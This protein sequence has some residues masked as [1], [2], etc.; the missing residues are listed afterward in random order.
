MKRLNGRGPLRLQ[1]EP[2]T[3]AIGERRQR[4]LVAARQRGKI[5]Q[6]QDFVPGPVIRDVADRELDLRQAIR[7][8]TDGRSARAAPEAATKCAEAAQGSCACR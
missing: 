6:H 1:V 2:D 8:T 5:A 4:A 7:A 3:M